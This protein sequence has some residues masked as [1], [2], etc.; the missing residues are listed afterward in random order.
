[1]SFDDGPTSGSAKLYDFLSETGSRTTHFMIGSNIKNN[2]ALFTR[3]FEELKQDIAVHTWSHRYMTTLTNLD[4][5]SEL[6]WTMEIIKNS[7]GGR[8]PR[9]WRPPYGDADNRVRAIAKEVFGLQTIFWNQDTSDWTMGSPGGT[10]LQAI[11]ASM[12]KWLNGPKTPGLMIL[13]HELTNQ[14]V[15]A[16]MDAYPIML[17]TGWNMESAAAIGGNTVYLNSK[18]STS[19]VEQANGV[20]FGQTYSSLSTSSSSSTPGPTNTASNTTGS[21]TSQSGNNGSIRSTI[22][23]LGGALGAIFLT[24][25]FYAW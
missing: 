7:T 16:F 15:E 18:D 1:L 11:N 8:L 3:A 13:E 19:P 5:V 20:L 9:Y 10:T 22:S 25:V 14:T 12:T 6:G 24:V 4:I 2:P 17:S 21:N 23:T